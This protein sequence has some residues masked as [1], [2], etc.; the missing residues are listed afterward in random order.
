MHLGDHTFV[1]KAR[2]ADVAFSQ[3]TRLYIQTA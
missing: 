2:E 3:W 1:H